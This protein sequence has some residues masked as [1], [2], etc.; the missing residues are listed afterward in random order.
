MTLFQAIFLAIVQGVTE[1]LPISSSGHLVLFQ[2]LFSLASP[3]VLFDVF[4]HLGTLMATLVFF[5]KELW[6][7]VKEWKSK[8]NQWMFLAVGS[9]PAAFFGLWLN[10]K[11][12]RIFDSLSLTWVMWIF[13]GI[14]L[15]STRWLT[16]G[17]SLQKKAANIKWTDAVVVGL[18]QAAALFPGISRSGSTIVGGLFRNFSRGNAFFLSFLL[19]VPAVFGAVILKLVDGSVGRINL[20]IGAVSI[21]IA[22]LVGYFSLKLLEKTLMSDKFY[23]FGFYSLILGTIVFLKINYL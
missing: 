8:K 17:K 4:L 10:S 15:V 20:G 11:T 19:S 21:I 9:I 18:F 5:R 22:G 23:L 2:K 14:L 1:F 12:D 6:S 13:F 3:P 7:L 16:K